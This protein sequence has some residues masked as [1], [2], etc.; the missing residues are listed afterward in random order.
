MILHYILSI[1]IS[2]AF[3]PY[4]TGAWVTERR[5]LRWVE[6]TGEDRV[7]SQTNSWLMSCRQIKQSCWN[8]SLQI[9]KM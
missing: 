9:M 1:T 5:A 8:T 4:S 3:Y 6:W 2:T 7:T